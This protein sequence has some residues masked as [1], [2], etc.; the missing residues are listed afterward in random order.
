MINKTKFN[1]SYLEENEIVGI[2]G[3][4]M[5]QNDYIIFESILMDKIPK[6]KNTIFTF[7][8]PDDESQD[9]TFT[10]EKKVFLENLLVQ[11]QNEIDKLGS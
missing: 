6:G 10:D 7:Y 2:S 5:F 4:A 9:E 1:I 3:N 11:C 8:L